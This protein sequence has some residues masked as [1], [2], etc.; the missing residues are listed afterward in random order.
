MGKQG[1]DH[2]ESRHPNR[3]DAG[4]GATQPGQRAAR[5]ASSPQR[6]PDSEQQI[7]QRNGELA[8]SME[9]ARIRELESDLF[10][11]YAEVEIQRQPSDTSSPASTQRISTQRDRRSESLPV[12]LAI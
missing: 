10:I 6:S 12:A 3:P 9:Q 1:A 2:D 7:T 5:T 4:T 8:S 11:S